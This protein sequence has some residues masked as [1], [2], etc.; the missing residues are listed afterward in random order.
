MSIV[1]N[2]EGK[3]RPIPLIPQD[4]GFCSKA[5]ACAITLTQ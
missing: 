3:Y 2:K 1:R 4:E 5:L